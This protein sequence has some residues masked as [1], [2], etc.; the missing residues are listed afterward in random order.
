MKQP[1]ERSG[2]VSSGPSQ[3]REAP[4]ILC[5]G[6]S[7]APGLLSLLPPDSG[8]LKSQHPRAKHLPWEDFLETRVKLGGSG[9]W[10]APKEEFQKQSSRVRSRYL[11]TPERARVEAAASQLLWPRVSF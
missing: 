9:L 3:A 4:S 7:P 10:G 5:P 2:A 6:S 1:L 11:Q 8:D